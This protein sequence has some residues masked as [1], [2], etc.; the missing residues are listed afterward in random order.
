MY[1]LVLWSDAD[2]GKAVIW[3]EDHGDLAFYR[4][5][6]TGADILLGA[7]DLVEFELTMER[8]FRY[9][10][11]PHLVSESVSVGLAQALSVG[12]PAGSLPDVGSNIRVE[13]TSAEI[14][15]FKPRS[16]PTQGVGASQRRV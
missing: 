11:N 3:C 2:A 16:Q 14:V 7:G 6:E 15:P 8:Q 9:A 4:E 5:P 10:R 1:G 12:A 13:R